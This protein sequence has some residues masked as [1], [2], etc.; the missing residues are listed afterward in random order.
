MKR[1]RPVLV[2]PA[3]TE[4]GL[5]IHEALRTCK[6]V[7]LFGA[8]Q[9]ISNHAQFV[10]ERYY[11]LPSIHEPGW[12]PALNAICQR[13]QIE[14]I[15]PAYDDVII[16]LSD[17]LSQVSA[18]VL[19]P[20]KDVCHITR[21]KSLTYRKLGSVVRVP[22]TFSVATAR[23][24]P[25]LVKPDDG[26]GS[27][28]ITLVHDR[29]QLSLALASVKNP[30]ICEYLPGEEYT[31]D[32]FS[33]RERGVL[34]AEARVRQRTRNG[35]AVHTRTVD[36]P[37]A[38]HIARRIQSVLP[39]R[40]AWFFQLKRACDG[41]L[42][43]LEVAPR[44]AGSM[45]AHRVQGVNFPLLTIFEH[46]R[47]PLDIAPNPMPVE[48]SRSLSNRY[49]INFAFNSLYVDLDDT[50]VVDGKVNLALVNLVFQC[51]NDSKPV[52]LVT[53]HNGDLPNI[54]KR[55]K[56]SGLFER[57]VH[58]RA[59]EPKSACVTEPDAVFVDDSF[60]ERLEV[61]RNCGIPTFD[62]SM[63]DLLNN[64]IHPTILSDEA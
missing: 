32:C 58:L 28:G 22:K 52:I 61:A 49:K 4:I 37:E 40:G 57:V 19:S 53:R 55:H 13:H 35:I 17:H 62:C 7:I 36:L 1:A 15:F 3:G 44:I 24:Y 46:E 38:R 51:V 56:L 60:S 42:A 18:V 25:L 11:E 54:L 6:E 63:I 45:S 20:P 5:E 9:P 30:I 34:F 16:A 64:G 26:Q 12:L 29:A 59:G 50:L 39:L 23:E 33:D 10:Y 21:V 43:L 14:Y 31:V 8:S 41:E 2:F 48:M 27:T 47:L